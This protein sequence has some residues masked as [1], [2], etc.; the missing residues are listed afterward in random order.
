MIIVTGPGRSGT[1][2]L[3]QLYRDLGFDPGG[4]WIP[5]VNAGM[6]HGD[7]WRLNNKLA[8]AVGATMLHPRPDDPELP[9][10]NLSK[11]A[12]RVRGAR[13]RAARKLSPDR[14]IPV[15]Q[16][17]ARGTGRIRMINW[18]RVPVALEKYG[19]DMV[20]LSK[21]TP[22]VKDPRFSF[23][24]PLWVEAGADIEHVTVTTRDVT[25]MIKSRKAAGHSEFNEIE[26]RNALTY[27]FGVLNMTLVSAG[28]SHAFIRFP[29]FL[30]DLDGLY[31][32]LRFPG[33]CDRETFK[34]TAKKLFDPDQVHWAPGKEGTPAPARSSSDDDDSDE[35]GTWDDEEG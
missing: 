1:S 5:R 12:R 32:A 2:V 10:E 35:G 23:T 22:V 26:L 18:D 7:F 25:Q 34:E 13:R 6:E 30:T 15:S 17:P 16:Q 14:L 19:K 21:E 27:G 3:A 20:R 11:L 8:K 24:L 9:P 31:D 28:I 33:P 29:D 4:N